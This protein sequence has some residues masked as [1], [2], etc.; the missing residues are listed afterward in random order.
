MKAIEA[1]EIV[2]KK[3]ETTIREIEKMIPD[4]PNPLNR[5]QWISNFLKHLPPGLQ[6]NYRNQLISQK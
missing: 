2:T 6:P 4:Y 5:R 1:A 3:P